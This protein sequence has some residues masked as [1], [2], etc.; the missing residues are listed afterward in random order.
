LKEKR[1]SNYWLRLIKSTL[2]DKRFDFNE[3]NYLI[4]ESSELAKILGSIVNKTGK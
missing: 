1:E 3:L 2:E 4:G